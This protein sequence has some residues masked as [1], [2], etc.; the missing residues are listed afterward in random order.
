MPD[1]NEI[2]DR[3]RDNTR[4]WLPGVG[5]VVNVTFDAYEAALVERALREAA[6]PTMARTLSQQTPGA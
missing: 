5:T 2:A 3:V 1:L 6:L 4:T